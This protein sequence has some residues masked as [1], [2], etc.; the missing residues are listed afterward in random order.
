M[1]ANHVLVLLPHTHRGRRHHKQCC[2]T[3]F[4]TSPWLRSAWVYDIR[5]VLTCREPAA[6][7]YAK[8]TD[9]Q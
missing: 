8:G 2:T 6:G 7:A 9:F 4:A 3:L 5:T 1:V